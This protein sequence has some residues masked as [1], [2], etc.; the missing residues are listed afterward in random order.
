[1]VAMHTG[2]CQ[3]FAIFD[4]DGK[5]AKPLEFRS[6]TFTAHARGECT[7]EHDHAEGHS[8]HSHGPLLSA[9][10][11]CCALVTRGLGPRLV[12]DLQSRGIVSYICRVEDVATAADQFAKGLL[13]EASGGTGCCC[14]H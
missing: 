11:D 10:G 12:A 4:V 14:H 13:D 1:M 5:T 8:H 2:R 6:N 3:G 7:G 9:I